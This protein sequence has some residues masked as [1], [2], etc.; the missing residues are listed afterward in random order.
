MEDLPERIREALRNARDF[1]EY[2]ELRVFRFVH[3]FSGKGDVLGS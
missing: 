2:Q 1:P 3:L